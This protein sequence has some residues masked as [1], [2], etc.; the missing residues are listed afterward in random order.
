M[1]TR[2]IEKEKHQS[3]ECYILRQHLSFLKKGK[4]PD[5]GRAPFTAARLSSTYIIS[6]TPRLF[7][8]APG[9]RASSLA[10]TRS[11]YVHPV[12]FILTHPYLSDD[13][14][15]KNPA[16]PKGVFSRLVP[17]N[18]R[19]P[20]HSYMMTTVRYVLSSHIQRSICKF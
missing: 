12:Y 5:Q 14:I 19:L 17:R 3:V 18:I 7:R 10:R 6:P 13:G 11:P 1:Y 20:L 4:N 2:S 15:H 9:V 16:L 8:S